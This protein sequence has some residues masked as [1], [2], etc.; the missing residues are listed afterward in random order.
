MII[1][2]KVTKYGFKFT[3]VLFSDPFDVQSC[4]QS[5]IIS[6]NNFDK[7]THTKLVNKTIIIRL[8]NDISTIFAGFNKTTRN[9]IN[10]SKKTI[11]LSYETTTNNYNE[12]YELYREFELNKKRLNY[13]PSIKDLSHDSVVFIARLEKK[14]ISAIHCYI[15]DKIIR[16]NIICSSRL[17]SNQEIKKH[18][19]L[20]TRRLIYEICKYGIDNKLEFLDLGEITQDQDSP[21][22]PITIFKM[23]FGGEIVDS[24]HYYKIYNPLLKLL[25]CITNK[26]YF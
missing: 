17:T 24:I 23:S 7:S 3:N 20:S 8:D 6:Y 19:S 15:Q 26:K 11:G 10:K 1:T 22:Y 16:I 9:E 14:P 5:Q 2:S 25:A 13:L 12:F 4:D 21:V 18:I